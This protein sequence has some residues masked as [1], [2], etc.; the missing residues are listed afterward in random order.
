MIFGIP[1]WVIWIVVG[2]LCII[3]EIFTPAFFSLIIGL[4]CFMAGITA[5]ITPTSWYP[6]NIIV[7]LIVFSITITI[8]MI[9]VRP[10]FLR[11][12]ARKGRKSNIEALIG[13]EVLVDSDIDN[14]K[15][16]GYIK[17][18]PDYF[19]AK[20][21]NGSPISRGTVVTIEKIEGITATV[22]PVTE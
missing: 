14:S 10:L 15:G 9:Y 3:I 7:Q 8:L 4:G 18:G 1:I 16:T 13:K 12:F 19:K 6:G 2:V 20:S 5:L 22:K 17:S 21:Y 11:Y